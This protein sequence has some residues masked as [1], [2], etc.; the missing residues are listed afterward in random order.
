MTLPTLKRD[1][2]QQEPSSSHLRLFFSSCG[3][4][5]TA[6]YSVSALNVKGEA[7]YV[8]TVVVKSKVPSHYSYSDCVFVITMT[9]KQMCFWWEHNPTFHT[10]VGC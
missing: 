9:I 7:S 4:T 10:A 8:A 2:S 3:F 1:I 5:D 6:Q